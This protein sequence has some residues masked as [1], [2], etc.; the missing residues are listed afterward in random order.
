[1]MDNGI[2]FLMVTVTLQQNDY[3]VTHLYHSIS[4]PFTTIYNYYF[5]S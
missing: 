1:V 4:V 2:Y 3:L 5:G